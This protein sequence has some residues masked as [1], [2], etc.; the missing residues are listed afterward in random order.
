MRHVAQLVRAAADAAGQHLLL[1]RHVEQAVLHLQT[2]AG[3]HDVADQHVLRADGAPVAVDHFAG[4]GRLADHVLPRDGFEIARIAQV[5][6]DDGGHVLGQDV[7]ALPAERHHGDRHRPVGAGGHHQRV[8]C[9]RQA[10]E[11]DQGKERNANQVNH[12]LRSSGLKIIRRC[13]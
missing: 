11:R 8:G 7:A 10:G 1:G 2:P 3:R 13:R 5:V 4:L 6:A 9:P 12:R